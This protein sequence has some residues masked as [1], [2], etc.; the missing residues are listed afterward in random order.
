MYI[1]D[2]KQTFIYNM[3]LQIWMKFQ[4]NFYSSNFSRTLFVWYK[5]REK[6]LRILISALLR[7]KYFSCNN[8]AKFV[9]KASL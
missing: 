8:I 1:Y 9:A 5:N 4:T 2:G 3:M 7:W 6:T